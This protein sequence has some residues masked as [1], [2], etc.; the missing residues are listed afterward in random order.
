VHCHDRSAFSPY[1]DRRI[2]ALIRVPG[3]NDL[4]FGSELVLE[5]LSDDLDGVAFVPGGVFGVV[6]TGSTRRLL[7][8]L[9]LFGKVIAGF[10]GPLRAEND[11][12]AIQCRQGTVFLHTMPIGSFPH[13][14]DR[15]LNI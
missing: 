10:V 4:I 7:G 8:A 13:L 12:V 11:P 14:H 1:R 5:P 3:S 6:D 2:A 15:S 9:Q